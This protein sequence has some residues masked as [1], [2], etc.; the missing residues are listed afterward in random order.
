MER[1]IL[2]I[3]NNTELLDKLE[4]QRSAK[5]E[6]S[7][8]LTFDCLNLRCKEDRAC[9]SKGKRLGQAKDSSLFLLSVLRGLTS[10]VCKTC[11]DFITDE[12]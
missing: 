5:R 11:E 8:R 12:E 6:T 2:N 10:G 7:G 9:C 3:W 4:R 1:P